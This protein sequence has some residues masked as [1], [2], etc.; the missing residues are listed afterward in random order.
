ML[1]LT[2]GYEDGYEHITAPVIMEMSHHPENPYYSGEFQMK[3]TKDTQPIQAV[4]I[5]RNHRTIE[6]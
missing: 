4:V 3:E 2:D 1:V 5:S 6:L